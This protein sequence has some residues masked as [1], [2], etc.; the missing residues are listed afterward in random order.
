MCV[1]VVHIVVADTDFPQAGA[2]NEDMKYDF[3]L[4]LLLPTRRVVRPASNAGGR[5]TN[6]K[7]LYGVGQTSSSGR[8]F[9]KV[10]LVVIIINFINN[11]LL[12]FMQHQRHQIKLR[13]AH[14]LALLT[15]T[16]LPSAPP[17]TVSLRALAVCRISG[18]CSTTY[19]SAS[20]GVVC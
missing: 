17:P 18:Y 19:E 2:E 8:K 11:N 16:R 10:I 3:F 7:I 20:G 1:T 9:I 15:T 5:E 12:I 6:T 14:H 4:S 13:T